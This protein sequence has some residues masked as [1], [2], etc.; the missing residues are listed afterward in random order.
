MNA[1]FAIV[2]KELRS[3]SRERTITIAILIQ[4]FIASFSS[5]IL[6]GLLS[7]YDPD[8]IGINARASVRV[9]LLGDTGSP[10]V[11]FLRAS[12]VRV[13]RFSIPTDA[14]NA[15]KAKTIDAILLVPDADANGSAVEMKLFLPQAE[16]A[17][18][19]ILMILKEPLKR[20]ENYLREERGVHVQY[21]DITG[22]PSTTFEFLYSVILP[23]LMFFPAFVAGSMTV[24]SISEELENHTL[25]TLSSAPLSLN[26]IFGA[27]IAAALVLAVVQCVAWAGLL[28]LN[29]I[30]I[31]NLGLVLLLAALVAALNAVGSAFTAAAL[32]DRERSQFL[33]SMFL[34][35]A[36]SA[37]Y[38]FNLS[39]VRL[40]TR[41]A[42]GDYATGLGN[43]ALYAV[44]LLAL[45]VVFFRS[46]KRL[47][48]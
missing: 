48:V 38:S 28:H 17:S 7:F 22:L 40:M 1:F 9:G 47:T 6:V 25:E 44:A 14:E 10:L 41:L 8:S 26:T 12:N 23:V 5:A 15:F 31:Q 46:T 24:D 11:G 34:L 2:K 4:L 39:P 32:K 30:E 20:Y 37:S 35:I 16:T 45:L 36:V 29:R 3:V 18:S 19:L 13:T 33:Y 43:V 21:T 27:K 42:T